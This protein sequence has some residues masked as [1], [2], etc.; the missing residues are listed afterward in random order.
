MNINCRS[1]KENNSEFKAAVDY[2]KPDIICGTESLLKGVKPGK[3]PTN[4]AIKNSE[5]FPENYNVFRNDR[6]TIGGGVFIAVQKNISAFE[7][8]D[9]VTSCEVEYAKITSKSKKHC[10]LEHFIC[11]T[12]N[13]LISSNWNNH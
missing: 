7:C 13:Y 2:V 8:V 12:E 10:I 6:G 5:I 11:H 4:D 1:V 3:S 9:F